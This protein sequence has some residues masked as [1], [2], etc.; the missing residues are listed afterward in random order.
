MSL[1]NS[2]SINILQEFYDTTIIPLE[3]FVCNNED[4]NEAKYRLVLYKKLFNTMQKVLV[5]HYQYMLGVRIISKRLNNNT[6]E[7]F[8]EAIKILNKILDIY[9]VDGNKLI[10]NKDNPINNF[11]DNLKNNDVDFFV[12]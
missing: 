3:K 6:P 2:K 7:D 9:K 8:E 1:K 10:H 12:K 5:N 11:M 4:N